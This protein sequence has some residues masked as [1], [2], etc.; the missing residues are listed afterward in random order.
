MIVFFCFFGKMEIEMSFP[1]PLISPPSP[2]LV[3]F[4]RCFFQI[5]WNSMIGYGMM[6]FGC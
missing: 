2:V 3:F 1:S 4:L 5:F 6:I